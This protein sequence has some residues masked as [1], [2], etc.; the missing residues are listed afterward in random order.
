MKYVEKTIV[1]M[2]VYRHCQGFIGYVHSSQ[3][4]MIY[5]TRLKMFR[6]NL[7]RFSDGCYCQ[8]HVEYATD[9]YTNEFAI[10]FGRVNDHTMSVYANNTCAIV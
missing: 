2:C 3:C 1:R 5:W 9:I 10:Y 7:H 6:G 8:L 4:F